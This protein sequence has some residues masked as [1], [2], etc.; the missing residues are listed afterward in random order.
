MKFAMLLLPTKKISTFDL[1]LWFCTPNCLFTKLHHST[2]PICN[3]S[4]RRTLKDAIFYHGPTVVLQLMPTHTHWNSG[5]CSS[6]FESYKESSLC[7]FS[8]NLTRVNLNSLFW[9]VFCS[10]SWFVVLFCCYSKP[11]WAEGEFLIFM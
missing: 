9:R 7:D 1:Y 2:S 6:V 3:T 5:V 8:N 11:P 10:V 4:K